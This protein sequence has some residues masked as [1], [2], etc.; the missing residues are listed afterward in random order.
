MG[1]E[2][3]GRLGRFLGICTIAI[4]L[5]GCGEGSTSSSSSASVSAIVSSSG[6]NSSADLVSSGALVAL[7]SSAYDV[8][9]SS[10]AVVTIF[11]SGSSVGAATVGYTTIDGTATAGTDYV[12]TSGTVTWADGDSSAKTVVVPVTSQASGTY[13]DFALTSIAGQAKFGSPATAAVVVSTTTASTSSSSSGGSSSSSSSSSGE[14]SS[15]SAVTISWS[16]PIY[17]T[18]GSA[19][20]NLA[21][22]NIYYGT[23]STSLSGKISLN[24]VGLLSYV[25]S[26]LSS[27]TWYFAVTSVNSAGVE[28]SPSATVSTTI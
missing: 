17:N 26:D 15:T 12:A 20:T 19:L 5:A 11:R 22:Y 14:T 10:S 6:G 28:S 4:V 7:S 21:G 9:P 27:G 24:T 18:N 3:N 13:F 16:A 1:F 2:A 23:N 8:A 25:I